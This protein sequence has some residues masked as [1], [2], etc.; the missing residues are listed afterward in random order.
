MK[1]NKGYTIVEALIAML[2][3]AIVVGGIFSA[4]MAARRAISEPSTREDVYFSGEDILNTMRECTNAKSNSSAPLDSDF[5]EK[6]ES[7]KPTGTSITNMFE[8]RENPYIL[9]NDRLPDACTDDSKSSVYYTVKDVPVDAGT[10]ETITLKQVKLHVV[11]EK[12]T[13]L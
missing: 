3:V 8:S 9:D 4:L 1:N 6:C 13:K 5:L 7:V 11:C 10:G 12:K 2:L